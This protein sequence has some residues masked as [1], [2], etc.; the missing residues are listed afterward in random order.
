MEK[1]RRVGAPDGER[2]RPGSAEPRRVCGT[3]EPEISTGENCLEGSIT[4]W[5]G[6][7]KHGERVGRD[8]VA[9]SRVRPSETL[10]D[11]HLKRGAVAAGNT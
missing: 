2:P 10:A 5:F 7:Y 1:G 11:D 3:A 4:K 6:L 9:R 8:G